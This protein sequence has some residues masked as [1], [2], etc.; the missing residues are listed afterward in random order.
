MYDIQRA[1]GNGSGIFCV[2]WVVMGQCILLNHL[3]GALVN[4]FEK[5][6]EE[7]ETMK[8]KR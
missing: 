2:I 3:L 8:E 6:R 1:M 7:L 4:N 5:K